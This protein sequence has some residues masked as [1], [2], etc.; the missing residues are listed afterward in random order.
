[1]RPDQ[2]GNYSVIVSNAYGSVISSN[3]A[4]RVNHPP[5][6]D[7]SATALLVIAC[8]KTDVAVVLNG[9]RSSD[10]DGDP[11]QY[12]WFESGMT[13]P[14]ATGVV[15]VVTLPIGT[16]SIVLTVDDGFALNR[17][18]IE[19]DVITT[20]QAVEQLLRQVNASVFRPRPFV[21]ILTAALASIDRGNTWAA[22]HQLSA[23]QS[24]V[25]DRIRRVDPVL[26]QKLHSASQTILESLDCGSIDRGHRHEGFNARI[27]HRQ[28]HAHLEFPGQAGRIYVVESSTDLVHWEK[29]GVATNRN[30][31][32]FDFDDTARAP[33]PM[34]FYRVVAP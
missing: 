31:G 4:L 30:D 26:A 33:L 5:V 11:L 19:V 3:A 15:A 23:F 14:L 16:N 24:L 34:R 6:A 8:D 22:A 1:M 17:Q 25:R 7:A 32:N 2:A 29:I 28:G 21:A 10:P 12:L 13:A 9:T 27:H 20:S 18:T